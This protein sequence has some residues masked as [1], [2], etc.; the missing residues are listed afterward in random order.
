VLAL[1][2][3]KIYNAIKKKN[4]KTIFPQ[5]LKDI[6]VNS[7]KLFIV[8]LRHALNDMGEKVLVKFSSH[9]IL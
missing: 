1:K 4:M 9:A 7:K 5:S 3:I 8:Q 2:F 6:S